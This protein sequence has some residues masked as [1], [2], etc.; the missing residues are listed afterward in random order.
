MTK[1]LR[2]PQCKAGPVDIYTARWTH[3]KKPHRQWCSRC[4]YEW[5]PAAVLAPKRVPLRRKVRP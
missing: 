5:K 3:E 1:P 2:C 4:G